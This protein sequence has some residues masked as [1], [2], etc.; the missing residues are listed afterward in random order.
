MLQIT[1]NEIS[2]NETMTNDRMTKQ[3]Q[4]TPVL[5][6]TEEP[7]RFL[8]SISGSSAYLRTGVCQNIPPAFCYSRFRYSLF[9]ARFP[10]DNNRKYR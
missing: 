2:N 7:D 5:R 4:Q 3:M 6:F 9:F 10:F 8:H 1:N